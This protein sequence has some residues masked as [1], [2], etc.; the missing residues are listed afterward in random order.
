MNNQNIIAAATLIADI[1]PAL[2]SLFLSQPFNR[3]AIVTAFH[4][5]LS[6]SATYASM[7]DK[8]AV[9]LRSA[10]DSTVQPEG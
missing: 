5:S 6:N 3:H 4:K 9:F 7:A 1:D 10:I 8:I 2:S